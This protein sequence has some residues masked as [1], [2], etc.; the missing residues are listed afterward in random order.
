MVALA[1]RSKRCEAA[2]RAGRT[3][4]A[5][6]CRCNWDGSSKAMKAYVCNELVEACRESHKAQVAIL[7]GDDN[8]STIKKVRE[9]VDHNVDKW[10][11]IVHV[12]ELLEAPCTIYRKHTKSCLVK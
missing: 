10:S 11:D 2:A 9:N 1:T 4:R 6:D 12:K 7:V 5:H 3:G 8:S